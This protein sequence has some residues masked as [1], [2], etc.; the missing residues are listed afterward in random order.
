M[1]AASGDGG[2]AVPPADAAMAIRNFESE[3]KIRGGYPDE[4]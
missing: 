2:A 3:N 1:A 4:M